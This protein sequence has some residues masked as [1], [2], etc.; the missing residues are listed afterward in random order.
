MNLVSIIVPVYNTEKYLDECL[1]SIICQ[2]YSN[3]EII[4]INDGSTD[5]SLSIC[6]KYAKIDK[7]IIVID[8]NNNGVSFSRNKGLEMAKG[9]YIS[10]I[11]SD[12][13]VLKNFIEEMVKAIDGFDMS[14]CGFS[15]YYK[16]KKKSHNLVK[17]EMTSQDCISKIFLND[18][19]GGY[20]C[21]KMFKN[22]I[23]K[24]NKL[25]FDININM[26]ED[27]MFIIEYLRR[28]K[29]VNVIDKNLYLYRMRRTSAVWN[30]DK[31]KKESQETSFSIMFDL[32]SGNETIETAIKYDFVIELLKSKSFDNEN[33]KHVR[34]LSDLLNGRI[35]F[36]ERI[37]IL[38]LEN[39]YFIYQWYMKIK[40]I[41]YK[42]FE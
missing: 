13:V 15:E 32:C 9:D 36:R 38:I 5:S 29:K 7:R 28:T 40:L 17:E 4:L 19:Y 18:S 21:T 1:K 12:D 25:K 22:D 20:S 14:L 35:S 31:R 11:D 3:L 8:Q 37:K 39:F 33:E 27:K 24:K 42:R 6:Q 34:Y 16:N 10:F 41:K 30:M 26:Q 23:I 2:T